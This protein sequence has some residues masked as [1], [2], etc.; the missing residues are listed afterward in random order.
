[1]GRLF[2]RYIP[3][4][5]SIT[6]YFSAFIVLQARNVIYIMGGSNFDDAVKPVAIMAFYPI[7][8]TYGQ[9]S[10]S[11]F[12]ATGQT[13]LYRNI[14][15][16]FMLIGLPVTY[17]FIAPVDKFGL[18][19]G[20]T[21]LAV[22]MVL[23][24]VIGVNVQLYFNAKFLKLSFWKYVGHQVSSVEVSLLQ[25][26]LQLFVDRDQSLAGI[27]FSFYRHLVS[28]VIGIVYFLPSFLALRQDIRQLIPD[29]CY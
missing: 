7:Y 20:S 12:Y 3:L 23:L 8:Q 15:V 27:R 14:G 18:N 4:L 1:M 6:A 16:L 26:F 9:L 21:G 17:F 13:S 28:M 19:L 10:G 2:R 29:L 11:V 22:K 24:Q 5:C 25:R